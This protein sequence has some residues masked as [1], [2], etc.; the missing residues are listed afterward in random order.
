MEMDKQNKKIKIKFNPA[1]YSKPT[2]LEAL[3][4][5]KNLCEGSLKH[6]SSDFIIEMTCKDMSEKDFFRVGNEF[7]N[8]T[9]GLMKNKMEV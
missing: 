5:F 2:L 8:Y 3:N 6:N 1:F 7:C 9:L 4:D